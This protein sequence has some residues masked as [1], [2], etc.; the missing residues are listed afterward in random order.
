MFA[1]ISDFF[2]LSLFCQIS[3]RFGGLRTC[4]LPNDAFIFT[5]YISNLCS[6]IDSN[7]D[8]AIKIHPLPHMYVV[9]DLVPDMSN[10]Y[11]QYKSIMPWL[12]RKEEGK[13]GER[14]YLQS[15]GDREKLVLQRH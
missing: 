3:T 14:Q 4:I 15:V 8:K 6:K 11:A 2:S 5:I 12:Q 10:F 7:L 1:N 9:K 13:V